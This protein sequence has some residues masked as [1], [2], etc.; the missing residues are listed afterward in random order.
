[1][2]CEGTRVKSTQADSEER[3]KEV[4]K[5]RVDKTKGLA[6]V[7]FPVR[8][9][10]R[11]QSFYQVAQQT[12]R[13]V[14]INLKEAYLLELFKDSG[15]TTPRVN[16][17]HIRIYVP[18]KTWGVYKDDRFSEKIQREDYDYWERELL[19]HVNAV[20]AKDI[21]ENQD[22]YIFRCDF[23]ELKELIDV[24]LDMAEVAGSN[25]AE[26]ICF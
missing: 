23:F 10:D 12:D 26:P 24:C 11:M 17:D 16:D 7:N 2:I 15:I 25:P 20:T 4:A 8:D 1:M 9:T 5:E 21:Q 13:A 6:T 14:V 18:R 3:V 19:D 22:D